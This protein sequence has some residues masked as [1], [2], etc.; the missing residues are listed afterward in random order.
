MKSWRNFQ[1][2]EKYAYFMDD[3]RKEKESYVGNNK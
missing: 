2:R 3:L 1:K